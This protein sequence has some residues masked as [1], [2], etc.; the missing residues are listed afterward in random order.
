[1]P[2]GIRSE[3]RNALLL[4]ANITLCWNQR[5]LKNREI[6]PAIVMNQ[7][8]NLSSLE[9]Q[10][11][12]KPLKTCLTV[13]NQ[14]IW[15]PATGQSKLQQDNRIPHSHIKLCKRYRKCTHSMLHDVTDSNRW[16][17]SM[18]YLHIHK[19][20]HKCTA[21]RTCQMI[22]DGCAIRNGFFPFFFCLPAFSNFYNEHTILE[23]RK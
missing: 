20:T 10:Y 22:T 19:H 5:I 11:I 6:N 12:S 16:L 17:F 7:S 3:Q 13:W 23:I 18:T 1:M 14:V 4:P 9:W 8:Q 2:L 15:P 21:R